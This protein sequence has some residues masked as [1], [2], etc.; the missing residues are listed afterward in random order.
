MTL[1]LSG[2][3]SGRIGGV[4][5]VDHVGNPLSSDKADQRNFVAVSASSFICR[6]LCRTA[7][8]RRI[9]R[10]FRRPEFYPRR[11]RRPS[12]VTQSSRRD[13]PFGF[14]THA[15]F[16]KDYSHGSTQSTEVSRFD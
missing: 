8:T 1:R 14:V 6:R 13:G 12:L 11:N 5:L 2:D 4:C 7:K 9:A 3:R 10:I 15:S 16:T